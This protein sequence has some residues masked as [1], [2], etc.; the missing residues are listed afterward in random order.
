MS[1]ETIAKSFVVEVSIMLSL[2]QNTNITFIAKIMTQKPHLLIFLK[3][4]IIYKKLEY[5][6]IESIVN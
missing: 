3:E 6:Q 4:Q 2:S 5:I 1:V